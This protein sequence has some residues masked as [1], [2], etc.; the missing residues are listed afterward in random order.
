MVDYGLRETRVE[1]LFL[2]VSNRPQ[3]Y[4]I[5]EFILNILF[6]YVCDTSQNISEFPDDS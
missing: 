1:Y 6:V 5:K 4:L 2:V 3:N